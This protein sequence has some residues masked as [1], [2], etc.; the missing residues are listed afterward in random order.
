DWRK[1]NSP[2]TQYARRELLDLTA[3]DE[4]AITDILLHHI[5]A[6]G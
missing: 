1:P 4:D 5:T 2:T 6:A 3:A